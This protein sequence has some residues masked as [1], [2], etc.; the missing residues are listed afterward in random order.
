MPFAFLAITLALNL[1]L[2]PRHIRSKQLHK[3]LPLE[4]TPAFFFLAAVSLGGM[5]FLNTWDFPVYVFI[6]AGAYALNAYLVQAQPFRKALAG[7]IGIGVSIGITGILFYLPFYLGFS[8]QAGGILPNLIYPTRGIHLWIMFA[9]FIAPILA[10]LVYSYLLNPDRRALLRGFGIAAGLLIGLWIFSLLFGW[11]ITLIPE[12]G[13]IYLGSLGATD[14][15][16]LLLEAVSRRI[17][18]PGGWIT[19]LVLLGLILGLLPQ[20][21]KLHHNAAAIPLEASIERSD[22]KRLDLPEIFAVLLSLTGLL[23]VLTPEFIYL[24][25]LFGWRM[26]TIFKFY[27]QAWLIWSIAAA[28]AISLLAV[29][30]KG[31][32]KAAFQISII[33]L[34]SASLVYPLLSLPT[35]TSN[36]QP[37]E[38]TLDSTRYFS[39]SWPDD[40]AAIEWLKSAPFG[41]IAEAVPTAGGSYSEYARAATLSGLPSVLGWVGHEN[42]WRG[43]GESVGSRQV[44]LEALFCSRDWE[45]TRRILE[46]YQVRYVFV[47]ALERIAYQ[48]DNFSCP[49]G[50]QEAKFQQNLTPVFQGGQV[51]I[52]EY[53]GSVNDG[54]S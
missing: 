53:P 47:G 46:E 21:K 18:A 51:T 39:H 26:N 52:Y 54:R 32:W 2:S 19:F 4:I 29:R 36:F 7:F 38:W 31:I 9:P 15:G 35:K 48:A 24:R 45:Q 41:V 25:D 5:A 3:Y 40:Q 13:M 8:S 17:S 11:A 44:D 50:L 34:L 28:F 42:Q 20:F 49:A 1:F 43:S 14:P 6:F 33:L 10:F 37:L 16:P 12:I 23:L 30:L 27:F 22:E